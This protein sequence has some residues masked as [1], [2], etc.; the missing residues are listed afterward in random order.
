M[1]HQQLRP[2][3]RKLGAITSV[4]PD[5]EAALLNLSPIIRDFGPD[6]PIVREGDRPVNVAVVLS[7]FVY[8]YKM[9]DPDKRQIHC[10]SRCRR[11]AGPPGAAP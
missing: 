2:L 7:G 10:V 1:P 11:Y 3:I 6:E 5:V 4:P 9:V 8:R